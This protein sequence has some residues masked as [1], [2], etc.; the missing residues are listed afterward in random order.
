VQVP[1]VAA[2]MRVQTEYRTRGVRTKPEHTK[3]HP[4]TIPTYI[5]LDGITPQYLHSSMI[6]LQ[7][8][9]ILGTRWRS[10][11][12]NCATGRK[13]AGLNPDGVIRFFIFRRRLSL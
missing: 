13:V 8:P 9:N 11:L 6:Y 2:E 12:R 5:T 7:Q 3:T 1:S 4:H 10:W